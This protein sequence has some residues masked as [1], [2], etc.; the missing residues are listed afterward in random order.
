MDMIVSSSKPLPDWIDSVLN[1]PTPFKVNTCFTVHSFKRK[2]R[3]KLNAP[4]V[5]PTETAEKQITREHQIEESH[6]AHVLL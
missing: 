2:L 4:S 6:V 5:C 1:N 3:C